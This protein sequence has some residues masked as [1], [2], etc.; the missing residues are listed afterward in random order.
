MVNKDDS[1]SYRMVGGRTPKLLLHSFHSFPLRTPE[2]IYM[3]KKREKIYKKNIM[4][5]KLTGARSLLSTRLIQV[6]QS[7][8]NQILKRFFIPFPFCSLFPFFFLSFPSQY[9]DVLY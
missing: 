6:D 5:S 1:P 9:L 7:I 8:T 3:K 4:W 2:S